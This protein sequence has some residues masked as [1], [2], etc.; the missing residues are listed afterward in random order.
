[1]PRKKSPFKTYEG[2]KQNDKHI[3]LTESMLTS[4]PYIALS[5]SAKVLYSYMKLWACGKDEFEY[6]I[7]LCLKFMS[8]PTFQTA[9]VEL[10]HYRF[11]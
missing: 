4:K 11:Y 8:N 2:I 5:N 7:T 6:P 10:I 3:R 1:M 9:K